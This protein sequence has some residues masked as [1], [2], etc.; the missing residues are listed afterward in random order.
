VSVI[1]DWHRYRRIMMR[2][3]LLAVLML[4]GVLLGSA[5]TKDESPRHEAH[6]RAALGRVIV[7]GFDGLEPTMVRKYVHEGRLPTFARLIEQGTFGDLV[8]VLPPSSASAWTSA[9]TGVNPGKHG[10]Y[11]FLKTSGDDPDGSPVFNTSRD[12]GF[13]PVWEVLG[14]YG[15][16]SY[17]VNI[18]LSSPA[19]SLDGLMIAGFPH[20]SDD[21]QSYY[22]PKSL[23]NLLDDYS[24]DAFRVTCAKNREERFLTKMHNIAGRRLNLGLELFEQ[25]GWDLFWLV[26][27]FPDRFQ[28]Y[29]WKY[30]D[31]SHPM[32]DPINGP[33][34]K[35]EIRNAY[36]LADT[37][38]AEFMRRMNEDDLLLVM[39]DHGF[40]YLYYTVNANNFLQRTLGSTDDV[41]CAD[42][43]GGKFII[44][45]SGPGSEERY[46]SIRKR[47][48]EGLRNLR[49]P[50]HDAPI[51][52]SIYVK[53]DIYVGP[54]L[55]TAPD[56]LCFEK[57]GYLFFTLPK[58]PDL[59]LL[60]SGP[61]PDKAFSGFHRRRGTF[62]AYGKYVAA[63][64]PIEARI[65]DIAAIIYSYLG[66]PAPRDIDGKV[67]VSLFMD[68]GAGAFKLVK[69]DEPGYR[70]PTGLGSQDQDK[71]EKQLRAVGYIQ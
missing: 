38:L 5:C 30:M 43:F 23:E 42:F 61:S 19:D 50:V 35:D 52:D 21:E 28:H 22:W 48:I 63:G 6:A 16:R 4:T 64:R 12:R 20:A 67:P 34:Y 46:L 25:R 51:I 37:Y 69:S 29:M 45:V 14:E 2:R 1:I 13:A 9:V 11:G 36:V 18:P 65:T 58:T 68:E 59:R 40:G 62:G 71:I 39:S 53:Q 26:F 54:Y 24:F 55:S 15:R 70:R 41:K 49:D 33:V 66:V 7:I 57:P 8:T 27:T 31:E 56:V 10:I 3:R 60:D 32:Y 47:L 44:D 17:I